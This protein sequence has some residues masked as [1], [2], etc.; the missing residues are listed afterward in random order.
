M[1]VGSRILLLGHEHSEVRGF[2]ANF[3]AEM[4]QRHA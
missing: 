4:G 3:I 1:A 2:W